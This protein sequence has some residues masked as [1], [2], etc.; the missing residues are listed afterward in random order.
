MTFTKA[1]WIFDGAVFGLLIVGLAAYIIYR[2]HKN[3]DR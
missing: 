3:R 1:M 2:R